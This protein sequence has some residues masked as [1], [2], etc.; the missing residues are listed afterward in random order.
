MLD[1]R[2]DI[3]FGCKL[4]SKYISRV[5][6]ILNNLLECFSLTDSSAWGGIHPRWVILSICCCYIH[7]ICRKSKIVNLLV[8]MIHLP[9]C[10]LLCSFV[11][12]SKNEWWREVKSETFGSNNWF[13]KECHTT[14][15]RNYDIN[16]DIHS[17]SL[18]SIG[19]RQ[20]SF[21]SIHHTF[22]FINGTRQGE[23]FKACR[24]DNTF[25]S[26]SSVQRTNATQ[27]GE[28]YILA[29][30]HLEIAL[31]YIFHRVWCILLGY[32]R[33]GRGGGKV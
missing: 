7:L 2:L 17:I 5:S 3:S 1:S 6:I 32:Y 28:S 23:D 25:W 21:S 8:F 29:S 22:P 18:T 15:Q 26:D 4:V 30:L 11:E 14:S 20:S 31:K 24:S 16:Y 27:E 10:W 9:S 12:R 33:L 13:V 19:L